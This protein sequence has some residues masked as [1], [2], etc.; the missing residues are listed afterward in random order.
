MNMLDQTVGFNIRR[1]S[2]YMGNEINAV[3]KNPEKIEV[4]I[5]LAFPDVYEVGMSHQGLKILYHILNSYEWIAAERVFSVWVD[6]EKEMRAEKRALSS[7]ETG[8]ILSDFDI[9][10]F[11]LQ[12]ELSYTNI[13]NMLDLSG[14][15]FL[16]SERD[17]S[18]PLVIGGGP[19]CFNPEPFA[20]IFDASS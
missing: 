4:K 16:S 1:P 17:D 11:S 19:A 2:R 14:V 5:A 20:E 9:I 3:I 12:H 7:L 15:P 18:F 8:R 13:L 10:G 6:M